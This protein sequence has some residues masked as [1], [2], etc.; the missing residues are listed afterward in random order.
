MMR[1]YFL[2]GATGFIGKA[3]VAEIC[4]RPDT[5]E[6]VLLT[7]DAQRNW[8]FYKHK[9]VS[10]YEGDI[11]TVRFPRS[12]LFT[13]IIHG[14]SEPLDH[15]DVLQKANYHTVVEGTRRFL[16]WACRSNQRILIMSSGCARWEPTKPYCQGKRMAEF[17]LRCNT[18][19]GKIARMY[20]MIGDDTPTQYAA[21]L[22]VRQALMD[23][24]I[25]VVGGVNIFRSYLHIEDCA[26]WLLAILDRGR[27]LHPYDVGG[28]E[29]LSIAEVADKVGGVFG[30]PV[31]MMPAAQDR[32]VYLPDL[33]SAD[34]LGLEQTISL[35][36]ALERIRDKAGL[37]SPLLEA[38]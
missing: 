35:K 12:E 8:E 28:N 4:R 29:P 16:D 34:E 19:T 37:R 2:T 5:E 24:K 27:A 17:L 11:A 32:D 36:Q 38:T 3:L 23:K 26:K 15:D 21:G 1:R 7:R 33:T 20:S 30:V 13:D 18:P 25:T 14:A 31:E 9:G 10:L 6:V 22:F